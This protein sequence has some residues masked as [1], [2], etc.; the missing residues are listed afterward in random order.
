VVPAFSLAQ[1]PIGPPADTPSVTLTASASMQ[2]DNDRMTIMLQSESEQ[3]Q[4]SA[5]A[6]EVNARMSKALATAKGV[7]GISA[8]TFSYT[9]SQVYEK[10]RMV[11][12]RVSQWLRV[13]TGDFAA[14]AN[15]A[16]KLQSEGLLLSSL[17][18]SVSPEARRA[19]VAKLQHDA[20]TEWQSLA[21]QAAASIGYAGY[22]PGRIAINAS[23]NVPPP[24]PRFAAQAMAAPA[25]EPVAVTAGTSEIVLT[26]SG[27]AI[28][29]GRR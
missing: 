26:V 20:L 24:P 15:L 28:L 21:K 18:F 5:A 10:G 19:A 2:V 9:T 23:D 17:V 11:R 4:A 29:T 13:E 8:R 1:V 7:P 22:V 3:P 16:T 6:N 12:W 14:G 25:A 27:D